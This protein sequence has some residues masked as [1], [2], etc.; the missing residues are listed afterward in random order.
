MPTLEVF[1]RLSGADVAAVRALVETVTAADTT[2]PFS[3]HVMLH[4]PGGGD[5]DVRHLLMRAEVASGEVAGG[6]VGY[7]HL[8]VT[9]PVAGPSAELAV[10]PEARRQGIGQLLTE[11]LL[12]QA[13]GG[14]LRLW[15][16]GDQPAAARM[17]GRMGFEKARVLCQ[18]RR[19]LADLLPAVS[20]PSDV[21]VRTFVVGQDEQAWTALNNAAFV[22]HP[23]QSNWGIEEVRLREREAWFDPA[24]FFL[25]TRGNQLIGFHWTKVHGGTSHTDR[26]VGA[27]QHEPLGEVYV[28]GVDPAE[29][30]RGLGP[31]LTLIGLHHLQKA[32]LSEVMLYVDEDNVN[33]VRVY[34][35][36]GFTRHSTDVCFSRQS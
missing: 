24:G 8:D 2:S 22:N 9:D 23:D 33:A 5:S 21:Q 20:L 4:L 19:P 32:G 13:P 17:A 15:A 30:G 27:H 34:Q 28:V 10:L 25:V 31:A 35:R 26:V 18:L 29:Q 3:E 16:H 7:A 14:R 11:D 1:R 12:R 6:L 36:L